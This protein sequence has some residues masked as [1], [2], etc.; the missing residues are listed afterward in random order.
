MSC[1]S[2]ITAAF[3]SQR[4]T[5]CSDKQMYH[6]HHVSR[7]LLKTVSIL[8]KVAIQYNELSLLQRYS[9]YYRV[10]FRVFRVQSSS[11]KVRG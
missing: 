1:F 3:M 9:R 8:I 10:L 2:D 5:T 6:V 4:F 7:H 11:V